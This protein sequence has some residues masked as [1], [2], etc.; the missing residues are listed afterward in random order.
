MACGTPVIAWNRGS[1]AEVIEDGI[2]GFIVETE[3]EALAAIARADKLDRRTIR[4]RFEQRFS[5]HI[6]ALAYSDVYT[7]SRS[8]V[9]RLPA[10]RPVGTIAS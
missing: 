9:P 2:T 8:A 3:E 5:S 10:L 6:M 1:V 7:R 4:A